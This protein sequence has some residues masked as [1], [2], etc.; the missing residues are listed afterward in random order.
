DIAANLRSGEGLSLPEAYQTQ[1][2]ATADLA[3][4]LSVRFTRARSLRSEQTVSYDVTVTNTTGR[5]LLLPLVLQLSPLEHFDREPLGNQGGADAGSWLIALGQGLPGGLLP[6]GQSTAG[7]TITVRDTG[8]Q[9]VSFLPSLTA[10]PG[11]NLP[12]LFISEPVTQAS[13]GQP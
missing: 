3:S 10:H 9:R 5:S 12:P 8:G 7:Q 2:T 1:F 6:A 4:V 13:A 11:V